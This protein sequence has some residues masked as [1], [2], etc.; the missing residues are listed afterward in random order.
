[1]LMVSGFN[2]YFQFARCFRQE[3]LRS[4]RQPEFT[5]LDLEMDFAKFGDIKAVVEGVL[6]AI[7]PD[8]HKDTTPVP[9]MTFDQVIKHYGSDKP[10]LRFKNLVIAQHN[11]DADQDAV[12]ESLVLRDITPSL[13]EDL[14]A[15]FH[16]II[17]VARTH[18][19][20]RE[21]SFARD[22]T[23]L[24]FYSTRPAKNYS[25]ST[26]LGRLRQYYIAKLMDEPGHSSHRAYS[27]LWVTDFPLFKPVEGAGRFESV[28]HPFT[29]PK[30]AP[31]FE[32]LHQLYERSSSSTPSA[33]MA[34]RILALRAQHY[35]LVLNGCEVGGGSVRLHRPELQKFVFR[36]LRLTEGQIKDFDHLIKALGS[37]APPH[38][39][40]ALGVDR[41]VALKYD[42]QSIRDTIAFPKNSKG[43]D[44]TTNAP[45]KI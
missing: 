13:A 20:S 32:A 30:D 45:E 1:M 38:A 25:G 12:T 40:I 33:D 42:C 4:D 26:L 43:F 6:Q 18:G 24:T 2:R 28:H 36:L 29:A 27:F 7:F 23:T 14:K 3:A 21:E 15:Y 37:G 17:E 10:D 35:D 19:E 31:E 11:E 39:G 34:S 22:G 16:N 44:L 41:L 9:V 5:Q 8:I